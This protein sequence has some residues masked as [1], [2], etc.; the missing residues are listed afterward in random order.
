MVDLPEPQESSQ[1]E[2]SKPKESAN[3]YQALKGRYEQVQGILVRLQN[4]ADGI[5][6]H[7][8]KVEALLTWRD[9][10]A[11]RIFSLVVFLAAIAVKS[12]GIQ[13]F[14]CFGII[15]SLRPPCFKNPI[16]PPPINFLG[17]L[18]SRGD[19]VL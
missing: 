13:F 1:E 4:V 12:L 6:S 15:W 16:P 3:P 9:P 2:A 17:R 8:E 18:P 7:M 11:S 14:L 10:T 5:A 19:Q